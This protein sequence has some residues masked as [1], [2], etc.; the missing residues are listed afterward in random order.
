[1]SDRRN[2]IKVAEKL[3]DFTDSLLDRKI[4][5]DGALLKADQ[6]LTK[7]QETVKS[8]ARSVPERDPDAAM[9]NRIRAKLAAEWQANG[10]QVRP[11]PGGWRSFL[12]SPRMYIPASVFA[13]LL[14]MLFVMVAVPGLN[15]VMPGAAQGKGAA[16][17]VI[18]F[19]FGIIGFILWRTRKK[20]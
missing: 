8:I 7:L 9:K 20:P 14:V 2:H 19:G 12:K 4:T 17:F 11:E 3:A 10:P 1:M 5:E 6:D 16:L 15:P 18:L 13:V